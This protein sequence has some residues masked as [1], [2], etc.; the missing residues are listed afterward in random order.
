LFKKLPVAVDIFS[1]FFIVIRTH[2]YKR[3]YINPSTASLTS[4]SV[5][6][7]N[8]LNGQMIANIIGLLSACLIEQFEMLF[9]LKKWQK[10]PQTIEKPRFARNRRNFQETKQDLPARRSPIFAASRP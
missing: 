6:I 8:H 5:D 3:Y 1:K 7:L 4:S 2:L 9:S 10:S